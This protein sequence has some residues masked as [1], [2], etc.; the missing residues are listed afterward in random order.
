MLHPRLL[1]SVKSLRKWIYIF[2]VETFIAGNGFKKKIIIT[3]TY[4]AN[5]GQ[6]HS[7]I[8]GGN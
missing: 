3:T 7:F 1:A 4:S 6:K 8:Q 2:V 5:L